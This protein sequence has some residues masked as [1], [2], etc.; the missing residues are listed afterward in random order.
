MTECFLCL[1]K[2]FDTF[3]PTSCFCFQLCESKVPLS[4]V[5]YSFEKAGIPLRRYDLNT[6][7]TRDFFRFC[8]FCTNVLD[9]MNFIKREN[10]QETHTKKILCPFCKVPFDCFR[11]NFYNNFWHT[12]VYFGEDLNEETEIGMDREE[13]KLFENKYHEWARMDNEN[14]RNFLQI[15]NQV[16]KESLNDPTKNI[17]QSIYQKLKEHDKM[18]SAK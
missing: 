2:S 12:L 8:D 4:L 10:E 18:A 16:M 15:F 5:I 9:K 6:N 14:F 3:I 17:I 11:N 1:Q 13:Q 7:L